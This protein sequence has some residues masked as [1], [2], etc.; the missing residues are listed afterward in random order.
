MQA[1]D[2]ELWFMDTRVW[3]RRLAGEGPD[4]L[5]IIEHR[6]PLGGSPPAHVHDDEDEV[7]LLLEGRIRFQVED[8][9]FE[10]QAGEACVAP[11]GVAHTYK[12]ISAEGARVLSVIHGDGFETFVRQVGRP[13]TGPGL[14]SAEP[15][16]PA[17]IEALNRIAADNRMTVVGPPMG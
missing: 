6:L 14:P 7:F 15:P 8:K 12:V 16:A 2:R 5:S 3:L 10:L 13:P 9:S 1:Q 11:R 4:G 17:A